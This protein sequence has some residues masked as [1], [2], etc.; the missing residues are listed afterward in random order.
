MTQSTPA[1]LPTPPNPSTQDNEPLAFVGGISTAVAA[2]LAALV[3]FGLPLSNAQEA[4]ILSVVVIVAPVVV[5]LLGRARVYSPK[6]VAAL[7]SFVSPEYARTG[8][9]NPPS[10]PPPPPLSPPAPPLSPPAT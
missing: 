4:S 8:T 10:T 3:A 9:I 5:T 7:L 2:V 6:S 1:N